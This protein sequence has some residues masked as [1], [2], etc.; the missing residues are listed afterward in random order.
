MIHR[1]TPLF[2]WIAL[3]A[4][5]CSKGPGTLS[6]PQKEVVHFSVPMLDG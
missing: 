3:L 2:A 5:S 4:V 1:L 6:D